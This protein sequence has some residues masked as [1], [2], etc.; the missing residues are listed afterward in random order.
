VIEVKREVLAAVKVTRKS[1]DDRIALE[2]K[3]I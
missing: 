3:E 1:V 2:K